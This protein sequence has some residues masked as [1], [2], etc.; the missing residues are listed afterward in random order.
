M[1]IP[2]LLIPGLV[3]LGAVFVPAQ[4]TLI[5]SLGVTLLSLILFASGYDSR[6]TG[7]RR[8]VIAAALA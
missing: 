5:V 3:V 2:A 1:L 4:R 6:L 7:S 8:M